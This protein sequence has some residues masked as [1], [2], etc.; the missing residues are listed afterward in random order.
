LIGLVAGICWMAVCAGAIQPG[1]EEKVAGIQVHGN[2]VTS[3]D[4]VRRLAGIDVGA[5]VELGTVE[6]VTER[7][8]ASKRFETVQVLKRFASI[9]DPS[10]ILLVIIVDEGPVRIETTG[11]PDR[12]TRVVKSRRGLLF[13]PILNFEDGYGLT[14]GA[15]L[16]LAEP[17]GKDSRLSFP[18]SWG[19]DKRAAAELDK[20]FQH[21]WVD[22]ITADASIFGRTNPFYEIDDNRVRVSARAERQVVKWVRAGATLGWQRVSFFPAVDEFGYGGVDVAFDTRV[23]AILPRNAVYARAAWEHIAGVNTTDLEA[24]GYLGLFG[25]TILA[26]RAERSAAGA[27]LPPYLKPL[28]GGMANLRGFRA[29]IAAG[30]NLVAT[31]AEVIVPLTSPLSFGRLGVSGFMDAGTAYDFGERLADQPWLEGYGGSVWLSAAFFRVNLAVA[32]GRGASTRVHLGA[33]VTF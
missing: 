7:L 10:Q 21:G 12:P 2:T 11:D 17:L 4:E 24:R 8:R 14:Y 22:R 18:L 20:R 15:R 3:D 32:H 28:L 9:S 19:G 5:P 30:D 23:D 31:S 27:P 13:L 1:P 25:Q 26:V 6:A 29:G 16:A 33:N